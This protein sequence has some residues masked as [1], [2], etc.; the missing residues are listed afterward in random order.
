MQKSHAA[1]APEAEN[2]VEI[3]FHE[4]APDLMTGSFWGMDGLYAVESTGHQPVEGG[5]G[6][7]IG[8]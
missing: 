5:I 6:L 7:L 4:K 3:M 1:F 8:E 2:E